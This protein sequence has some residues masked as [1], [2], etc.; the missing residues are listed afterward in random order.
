VTCT[1]HE[2]V[3]AEIGKLQ[4]LAEGTGE[5]VAAL[6]EQTD[7]LRSAL[8]ELRERDDDRAIEVAEARVETR[9][10][11]ESIDKLAAKLDRGEH[12]GSHHV[13]QAIDELRSEVAGMKPTVDDFRAAGRAGA[14]KVGPIMVVV[15]PAVMVVLYI[16]SHLIG[17]SLPR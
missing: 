3:V 7:A 8:K 11:R 10:L 2:A 6:R 5:V 4:E 16:I 17:A 1:A 12:P 13:V 9:L 15:M 14:T